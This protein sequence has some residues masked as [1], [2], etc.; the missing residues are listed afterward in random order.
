MTIQ[1]Y[2]YI[3]N[4]YFLMLHDATITRKMSEIRCDI[5]MMFKIIS[6]QHV[7]KH[8]INPFLCRVRKRAKQKDFNVHQ[9]VG[10]S[11]WK[12]FQSRWSLILK[13]III[14]HDEIFRISASISCGDYK[15]TRNHK[16]NSP[17]ILSLWSGAYLKRGIKKGYF[18]VKFVIIYV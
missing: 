4:L 9:D 2:Q 1:S 14:K 18:L 7:E 17:S 8:H 11:I 13:I 12:T 15:V 6:T 16:S 5:F 10:L 3:H